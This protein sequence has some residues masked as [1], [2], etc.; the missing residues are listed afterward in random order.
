MRSVIFT[1]A[2]KTFSAGIGFKTR[3]SAITFLAVLLFFVSLLFIAA[4][5]SLDL[6]DDTESEQPNIVVF[7][8]PTSFYESF[9]ENEQRAL[10]NI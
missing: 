2:K 1:L 4:S 6:G 10:I 7:N 3:I 9:D 8:A 5:Y